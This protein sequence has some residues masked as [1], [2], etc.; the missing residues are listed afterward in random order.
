MIIISFTKTV[1][2]E[3]GENRFKVDETYKRSNL[4]F[5]EIDK[6]ITSAPDMVK[7]LEEV[8]IIFHYFLVTISYNYFEMASIQVPLFAYEIV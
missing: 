7:R 1:V 3:I 2:N 4:I 5:I 6:N 8:V